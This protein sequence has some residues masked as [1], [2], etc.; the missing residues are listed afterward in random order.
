MQ[1][2]HAKRW[3]FHFLPSSCLGWLVNPSS[4]AHRFSK[5]LMRQKRAGGLTRPLAFPGEWK[6]IHLDDLMPPENFKANLGHLS[7]MTIAEIFLSS[8]LQP[9]LPAG[10]NS[11][12]VNP[13]SP[14]CSPFQKPAA[15]SSNVPQVNS[16][17]FL[18]STFLVR[19]VRPI[20]PQAQGSRV[21]KKLTPSSWVASTP[22][23]FI[24]PC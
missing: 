1:Q 17:W 6:S 19:G 4:R 22:C 12:T 18:E 20:P 24:S 3:I 15:P 13:P 14:R 16:G 11:L 7:K 5:W 8:S 23:C 10:K 9:H 2:K 21:I